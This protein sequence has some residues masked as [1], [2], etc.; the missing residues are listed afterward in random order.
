M[1][2][3]LGI[4]IAVSSVLSM[5]IGMVVVGYY[6]RQFMVALRADLAVWKDRA[7]TAEGNIDRAIET[8]QVYIIGNEWGTP[9]DQLKGTEQ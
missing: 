6:T 3:G 9:L 4:T 7:L 8:E 2:V 5:V 1:N